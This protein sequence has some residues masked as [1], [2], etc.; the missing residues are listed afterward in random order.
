[1]IEVIKKYNPDNIGI[2]TLDDTIFEPE[3]IKMCQMNRCGCYGKNYTCPPHVGNPDELIQKIKKYKNVI[4]FNKVYN[5]EDSFD[6]EGMIRGKND[7]KRFTQDLYD[8]LRQHHKDFIFF[9]CR[10]M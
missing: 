1:M 8:N 10:R 2:T 9:R 7:F 6:L 4:V 5:I 3:L